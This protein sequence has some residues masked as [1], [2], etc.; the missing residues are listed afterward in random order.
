MLTKE[1]KAF[2]FPYL[3]IT[4][5]FVIRKNAVPEGK[6]I[7][8]VTTLLDKSGSTTF[9]EFV[10]WL[11]LPGFLREGKTRCAPRLPFFHDG[12]ILSENFCIFP[13]QTN[14][15]RN[16]QSLWRPPSFFSIPLRVLVSSLRFFPCFHRI[17]VYSDEIWRGCLC[18]LA[19]NDAILPPPRPTFRFDHP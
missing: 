12:S 5:R 8:E 2:E 19:W 13:T 11:L 18:L 1:T 3:Y 4:R 17:T 6:S 9:Q 10:I 14:F 16:T 15:G 7:A